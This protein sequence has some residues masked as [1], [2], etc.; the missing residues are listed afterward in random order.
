MSQSITID[1]LLT[2]LGKS[3]RGAHQAQL[4]TKTLAALQ[5]FASYLVQVEG[6]GESTAKVYKSLCA[7]ALAQGSPDTD[8]KM[9]MSALQALRRFWPSQ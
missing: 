7:K 8:N 5:R 4:D 2:V 9:M 1:Q 6:K 3:V